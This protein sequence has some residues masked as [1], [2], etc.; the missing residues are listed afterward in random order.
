MVHIHDYGIV[1]LEFVPVWIL[2]VY[3]RYRCGKRTA[4]DPK[5]SI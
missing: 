2:F 3:T 4:E 1:W 5:V